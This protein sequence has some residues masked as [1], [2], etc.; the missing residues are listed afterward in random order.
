MSDL[1]DHAIR[2]AEEVGRPV[3]P[4][5]VEPDPSMPGR[6]VKKPLVKSWQNG[7]SGSNPEFIERLFNDARTATHAGIV[8][9]GGLL[10]ID[11]D[12]PPG[13]AWWREHADILPA[14]RLQRTQRDG[15]LHLYY[16]VARDCG[17]RNSA[18]KIADGVDIRCDGGFVVD[19]SL[20]FPPEVTDITEAPA[21]LVELLRHAGAAKPAAHTAI[22][23]STAIG[24]GKRNDYLSREAYRF[25]KQGLPPDDML[26]ALQ[27][28]NIARCNPPLDDAEIRSIAEGKRAVAPQEPAAMPAHAL[29]WYST[30]N[31]IAMPVQLVSKL[32]VA[33]T[34]IVV[35]GE[36]NSGKTFLVL[37]LALAIAAGRPWRGLRTRGGLVIYVAGEGAA[38]VR[39]RVLAYRLRNPQPSELPFAILPVA[40]NFLDSAS[41]DAAI[42]LIRDAETTCGQKAALIVVDTFARSL[43]GGDENSAQDV[44]A[45]VAAADRIRTDTGTAVL[46]VHHAGKDPAKGARGSSALRAAVDTEILVEGLEGQ[47]VASI[48]KQRDLEVG[49]RFAFHLKPLEVGTDPDDGTPVT[50]CTVEHVDDIPAATSAM[51]EFRGKAQRQFLAALRARAETAPERIWSLAELRAVARELGQAKNT[52]R[53]VVDA[54]T[55][56][57]YM[58]PTIGGYFFTDGQPGTKGRNGTK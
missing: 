13:T 45:G 22:T 5:R 12:G 6:T 29:E 48:V 21:E 36:S 8:T 9:G 58:R 53:S 18:S 41:I 31:T 40:V 44:G 1:A 25:R 15:G 54:I 50:S 20:Q 16:A 56:S 26:P 14:T 32:L 55:A 43:P 47:R 17:L 34:L 51:R 27:A 19:W 30:L 37:D 39:I 33:G 10:V 49:A 35:Y 4:V 11:L 7:G 28:L 38:S 2:L 52:A 23:S 3:F 42:A 24:E 46:F 57:E